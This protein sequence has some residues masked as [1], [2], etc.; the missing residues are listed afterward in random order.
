MVF[1]LLL[2]SVLAP[3]SA[4]ANESTTYLDQALAQEIVPLN[5]GRESLSAAEIY[6]RT[7]IVLDSFSVPREPDYQGELNGFRFTTSASQ[8]PA[9][10]KALDPAQQVSRFF[11]VAP[12]HLASYEDRDAKRVTEYRFGAAASVSA[13]KRLS[14]RGL[15]VALDPGHMGGDLWDE[16]TG[17][18]VRNSSGVKVS[19]GVINLQTTL[20]VEQKLRALGAEVMIT[21]RGLGP[22][23]KLPYEQLNVKEY[24]KNELRAR[25][26]ED[27]FQSLLASTEESKLG[28]AFKN[29]SAVKKIFAERARGDYYAHREDLSA[30]AQAIAAFN[31]DL[32]I[33][34]H[35]DSDSLSPTPKMPNITRAYVPGS[36]G[37]MEF[38]TGESRARFLAHLGQG[39]QWYRSVSLSKFIINQISSD[40]NVPMPKTDTSGST[41]IFPGV[42]AR[43]LALTRQITHAPIT[44]LEC[45]SYGNDAEFKRLS[46][47]DGGTL[48]IDGKAVP[49]SSRLDSLARAITQGVVKYVDSTN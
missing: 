49:Y 11:D 9:M 17:K 8:F 48:M 18:F 19:E 13:P 28:S 6:R 7:R 35:F 45:L 1:A 34:V 25:S 3:F 32:T 47:K 33:V 20:L 43:N 2:L 36:F 37:K 41:P 12:S 22:V 30:R 42:F 27:W 44:Y 16:R 21:H 39:E 46:Q 15:R 29:S 26:L 10:L 4:L 40:L 38:A 5:P 14:L 24:G 31:P 23:S